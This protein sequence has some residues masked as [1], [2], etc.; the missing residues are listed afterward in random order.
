MRLHPAVPVVPGV[1][2]PPARAGVV[3]LY[4]ITEAGAQGNAI[5]LPTINTLSFD[6]GADVQRPADLRSADAVQDPIIVMASPTVTL[7]YNAR[8]ETAGDQGPAVSGG[9][10]D[11][12]YGLSAR[13]NSASDDAAYFEINLNHISFNSPGVADESGIRVETLNGAIV[14]REAGSLAP[15]ALEFTTPSP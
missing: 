6:L 12:L 2:P 4:S 14:S 8:T 7:S 1:T 10:E 11:A 13:F 5:T 3:S 15:V 9:F